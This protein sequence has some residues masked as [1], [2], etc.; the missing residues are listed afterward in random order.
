MVFPVV[1]GTQDTVNNPNNP[2]G[3]I[4]SKKELRSIFKTI[5]GSKIWLLVDE[6]YSD[7]VLN[8]NFISAGKI[9]PSKKNLII[10]WIIF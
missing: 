9:L 2:A 8:K 3:K 10:L 7:F 4:Y 5:K 1:G 6:A